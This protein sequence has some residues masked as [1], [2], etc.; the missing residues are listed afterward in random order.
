[1]PTNKVSQKGVLSRDQSPFQ[2]NYNDSEA[3]ENV[4]PQYTKIGLQELRSLL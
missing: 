2:R 3:M 1:M 4:K